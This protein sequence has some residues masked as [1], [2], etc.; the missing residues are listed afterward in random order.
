MR[1]RVVAPPKAHWLLLCSILAFAALLLGLNTMVLGG[2]SGDETAAAGPSADVP[3]AVVSGGA[4]IDAHGATPVARRPKDKTIALTFDDGPDPEW[5]PAVLAVLARY[6]VHAT[7][8]E[9]GAHVAQY[10]DLV[11][12]VL[13]AGHEIGNHTT[14]HADLRDASTLRQDL[15]L[16][17][18]DLAFA[19]TVGA[20]P[21]L[22]RPPYVAT[23]ASVDNG[24]WRAIQRIGA[25]GKIVVLSD[26]DSGDWQ[27]PGADRIV[28]NAT[29]RDN[30]GAVVLFHDAGGDRAQTVTALERLIPE[31]RARGW[32]FDT[33]SRSAGMTAASTPADL[34]AKVAGRLFVFALHLSGFVAKL[35]T[36]LM[37]AAGVLAF[38]RTFLVLTATLS[39]VRRGPRE[40]GP[41]RDPVTVIVP[42]YNEEAGIE[43]TIRSILASTHPVE[44][45][46]VDDGSTD[47]TAEVVA[48]LV[49][50]QVRLIRQR[51][52]GKAAALNTGLAAARTELV[53]LVDGDTV[54]DE[55]AVR[56]LVRPFIDENVGAVSGNAKVANR[57]GLLGRWQ[58]IEYVLGFN[59]DRRMYDVFECMPTVP[60]ALGA[61]RR[62]AVLRCGGV[63]V[64]TLAED[65]DLTMLL[66]RDGWR[67]LYQPL[68]VAWTE[69]PATLGQLWKQRYRWCYGTLQAVWKHRR[70]I[71]ERGQGGRLGRRGLPYLLLFQ[72]LLPVLA[73]FVDLATVFG[74]FTE[75]RPV[76]LGYWL[77]FQLLQ[78]IPGFV[79]FR[80]DRE[81]LRP[82]LALPAQQ[83]VYRQLM[84]LVVLQSV[85]TALAG[86]RLPWQKLHRRGIGE[87]RSPSGAEAVTEP[88]ARHPVD[89]P[90]VVRGSRGGRAAR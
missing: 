72:V 11:R 32:T 87:L 4:L 76:L 18:T 5:T 50:S 22:V 36:T 38:A 67:V 30:R 49:S 33:V 54:L 31:L 43:A 78:L 16:Q 3:P 45:I 68:A 19:D 74:L 62:S 44:V 46:V 81:S 40:R 52:A 75:Q 34:R 82:L 60:G 35:L 73:P 51:N 55:R 28:A 20:V 63:P 85:V 42:A 64:D 65:T 13:A 66:Q 57:R 80:L 9:T 10:P 14:S 83:F 7:F 47:G 21:S 39:H 27:R 53:V 41:G 77:V 69:A 48:K 89:N 88:I 2:F 6:Q 8:F 86:V 61:F 84:Y 58:H 23:P 25:E 79:A 15:E 29:P 59:L 56:T 12:Q 71:L 37:I 90:P 26:L 70:S 1:H 17:A 24:E